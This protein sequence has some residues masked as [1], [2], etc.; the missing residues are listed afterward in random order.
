MARNRG[1]RDNKEFWEAL[2]DNNWAYRL[3][4]ERL[5]ELGISMFEWKNLPKSVDPRFL[6]LVLFGDGAAVFFKDEGLVT[7]EEP[8]AG[9]LALRVMF[10]AP[11]TVYN[12]PTYRR[13]YASNS[14][15][16]QLNEKNSVIIWNNMLH[17]NTYPIVRKY[18]KRLWD[19]DCSIDV[20]AKAQKTPVLVLADNESRMT[21]KN[22][23]M[24]YDG[25]M[26]F[27][28]GYPDQVN[29]N[30][31][32]ALNTQAPYVADKLQALKTSLWN[33]VLTAL[34]ITNVSYQ[35]KERMITDEV[36]RAQGGTIASRY[37]RLNARREAAAQINDM[38]GLNIEVDFR[39][40]FREADDDMMLKD[41]TTGV[42]NVQ[43]TH[44]AEDAV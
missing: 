38:F 23:Y 3:Y 6:E 11:L 15:Q 14:Y 12:I 7:E 35:K 17:T 28:Y 41:D 40:D 24:Q 4:F 20:N 36:V 39:A 34:G 31:L 1:N 27:I 21:M 9:Y 33:E 13:A 30:S 37:S 26:P 22:L 19:L 5:M 32:K 43:I 44:G 16:M 8:D 18:A 10:G 42:N 2:D 25:N 29:P